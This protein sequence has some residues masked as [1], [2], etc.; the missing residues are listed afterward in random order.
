M[1][2]LDK[3]TTCF[4]LLLSSKWCT[5]AGGSLIIMVAKWKLDL[6]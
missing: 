1:K 3:Q 2:A 5:V 6:V 4:I